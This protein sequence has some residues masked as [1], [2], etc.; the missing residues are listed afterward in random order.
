VP[1][2]VKREWKPVDLE[3]LHK[4]HAKMP[5]QQ[6]SAGEFVRRMRDDARY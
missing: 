1:A 6:E 3:A 2:A 5:I 4:L